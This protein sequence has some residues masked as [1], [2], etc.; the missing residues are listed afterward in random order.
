MSYLLNYHGA[1][2][3][4]EFGDRVDS[5][6]VLCDQ[7]TFDEEVLDILEVVLRGKF[8]DILDE[9]RLWNAN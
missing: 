6:G 2:G 5:C 3:F 7:S 8:F 4:I 1:I 9:L